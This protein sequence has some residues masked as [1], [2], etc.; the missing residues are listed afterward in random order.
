ML[1]PDSPPDDYLVRLY[2]FGQNREPEQLLRQT[3]DGMGVWNGIRFVINNPGEHC[4]FLVVFGS[5]HTT[6]HDRVRKENTLFIASEPPAIKTYPENYLAQ[7]GSV[8]TSDQQTVH[9]DIT[10]RQQGYPW[11]C[12]LTEGA[13][14]TY[15]DYKSED[16]INKTKTISV[17]C[18]SKCNKPGHRKRFEFVK[19]LKEVMGDELD[20]YGNGQNF[21]PDK[22]DAI[23]PYKYHIAIENSV[24]PHYWSEKLADSYL[25][26]AFPFYCGCPNIDSYFHEDAYR[27]INLDDLDGTV[28][29]IREAMANDLYERSRQALQ[30]AK[31]KVLDDYNLFNVITEHIHQRGYPQNPYAPAYKAYPGKWFRKGPLYRLKF[32]LRE[33]LKR[34]P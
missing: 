24:S 6:I 29:M 34:K 3:P 4:D 10:F 12:G 20:L 23:R 14:K 7:F 13:I 2:F 28:R 16:E 25:E 15:D 18:S 32:S 33:I 9:P 22:A 5:G 17:V 26:A 11:F 27:V 1:K 19:R 21:V 30:K 8:I 31:L